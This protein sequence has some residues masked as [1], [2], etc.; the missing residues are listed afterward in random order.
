MVAKEFQ[1]VVLAAGHGTRITDLV[2][3]RPKC[4]I[5]IGPFPL[6]FYP[7]KMLVSSG[8]TGELIIPKK[9]I[10]RKYNM[11]LLTCR[12]NYHRIGVSKK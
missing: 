3:N 5:P 11:K 9:R 8:F 4:L 10:K 2:G 1:A 7:L 12:S 6:I